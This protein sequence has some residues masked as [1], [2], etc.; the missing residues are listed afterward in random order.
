MK[1]II[2]VGG[3][4]QKAAEESSKAASKMLSTVKADSYLTSERVL[5]PDLNN[6]PV[7]WEIA[8]GGGIG[9]VEDQRLIFRRQT[10]GKVQE[11]G[12]KM[13]DD[14]PDLDWFGHLREDIIAPTNNVNKIATNDNCEYGE[15]VNLLLTSQ[16]RRLEQELANLNIITKINNI[17]RLAHLEL[18]GTHILKEEEKTTKSLLAFYRCMHDKTNSSEKGKILDH[19][20]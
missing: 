20:K 10:T 13:L 12:R 16:I 8:V 19:V 2:D 4:P 7:W 11:Y 6:Y 17:K 9:C 5:Y 15:K 14:K 1:E 3:T 18:T